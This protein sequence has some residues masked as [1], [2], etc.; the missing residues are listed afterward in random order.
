MADNNDNQGKVVSGNGPATSIMDPYK[1][2]NPQ[3]KLLHSGMTGKSQKVYK[4]RL[5][6][7][8]EFVLKHVRFKAN[9]KKT[10]RNLYREYRIGYLLGLLTDGVAESINIQEKKD[11]NDLGLADVYHRLGVI[12]YEKKHHE[13]AKCYLEKVLNIRL[14]I[15]KTYDARIA[16]SYYD[17]GE[18]YDALND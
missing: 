16:N 12:S 3:Y 8:V 15:L 11:E 10:I 5:N 6:N 4:V 14:K 13:E 18:I 9:D 17:L 2:K 7:G 1:D